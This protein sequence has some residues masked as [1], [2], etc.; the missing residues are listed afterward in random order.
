MVRKPWLFALTFLAFPPA[1][2]LARAVV[3]PVDSVTAGLVGGAI[4]G[5]V[6]GAA[7]WLAL[8]TVVSAWWIAATTAAVGVGLAVTAGLGLVSTDRSDLLA[9]GLVTGVLVGAAQALVLPARLRVAWGAAVAVLWPL[10]WQV[11]ALVGVDLTQGWA[12]FGASGALVYSASLA[13]LLALAGRRVAVEA[14]A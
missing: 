9:I 13:G 11:T 3:G 10:A 12:V 14:T 1:G 2:L 7:Q 8:R 6:V 4:V 5:L